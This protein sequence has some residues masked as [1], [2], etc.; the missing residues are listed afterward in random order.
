[1]S[2]EM[3]LPLP[4]GKA[5]AL[6]VIPRQIDGSFLNNP[7]SHTSFPPELSKELTYQE[8]H[9]ERLH[10]RHLR[11][12]FYICSSASRNLTEWRV[13]ELEEQLDNLTG[14]L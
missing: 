11:P 6:P 4:G 8:L 9:F 3:S 2:K 7:L 14:S 12:R 10:R 13:P 5:N 1:M